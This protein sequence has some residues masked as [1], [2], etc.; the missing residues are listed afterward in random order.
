M[1]TGATGAAASVAMGCVDVDMDIMDGG[2]MTVGLIDAM[3]TAKDDEEVKGSTTPGARGD[4]DDPKAVLCGSA[5]VV[6]AGLFPTTTT[7]FEVFPPSDAAPHPAAAPPPLV[8]DAT[9]ACIFLPTLAPFRKDGRGGKV[10][11]V[12][13]EAA[14]ALLSCVV[15]DGRLLVYCRA[16]AQSD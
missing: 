7:A 9:A 4:D 13:E 5:F 6:V 2:G 8:N 1:G 16:W 12:A 10:V 15:E 14:V 3:G 11:A